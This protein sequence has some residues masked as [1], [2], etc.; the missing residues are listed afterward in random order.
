MSDHSIETM[1][2]IGFFIEIEERLGGLVVIGKSNLE[3]LRIV[4][5]ALNEGGTATIADSF[6]LR[7]H[8]IDVIGS[9]AFWADPPSADSA[10][11]FLIGNRHAE[12]RHG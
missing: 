6:L 9:S 2:K 7:L 1:E 3:A 10:D 4:V 12:I 11:Q 8:V 5:F